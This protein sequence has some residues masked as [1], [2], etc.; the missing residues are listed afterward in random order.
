MT[1]AQELPGQVCGEADEE[2][3]HDEQMPD[4]TQVEHMPSSKREA[5]MQQGPD[6]RDEEIT[7]KDLMCMM[8]ARFG[9]VLDGQQQMRDYMRSELDKI[10]AETEA[11]VKG[12]HE[13]VAAL[14]RAAPLGGAVVQAQLDAMES[15]IKRLDEQVRRVAVGI[16]SSSSAANKSA[17]GGGAGRGSGVQATEM[18]TLTLGFN[19]QDTPEEEALDKARRWPDSVRYMLPP[20]AELGCPYKFTSAVNLKYLS[21]ADARSNLDI[22]RAHTGSPFVYKRREPNIYVTMLQT[23]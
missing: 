15:N 8:Q 11:S 18:R 13:M 20:G 10:R 7:M 6:E 16:S 1:L 3:I 22:L 12:V 23:K 4:A 2:M 9:Q 17:L 5:L 14:E 21:A 19:V